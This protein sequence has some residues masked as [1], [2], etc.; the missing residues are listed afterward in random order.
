MVVMLVKWLDRAQI[1]QAIA[2]EIVSIGNDSLS[3]ANKPR[4]NKLVVQQNRRAMRLQTNPFKA[5]Y[6]FKHS[7]K[8]NGQDVMIPL[9]KVVSH[10]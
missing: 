3:R 8:T 5:I 10:W 2:N 4:A 6:A 1:G 7:I 9:T